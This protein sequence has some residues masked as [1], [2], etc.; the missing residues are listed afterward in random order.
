MAK[1]STAEIH[2]FSIELARNLVGR[3]L[4]LGQAAQ[5]LVHEA[6]VA[7]QEPQ[8]R[9]LAVVEV[10]EVDAGIVDAPAGILALGHDVAA[11]H[12]DL[13]LGIEDADVGGDLGRGLG[14]VVLGI[15]EALVGQQQHG[16]LA[17][18]LDAGEAEI[19]PAVAQELGQRLGQFLARQQHGV[20]EMQPALGIG[21]ELV[22]QDAL[23]D[24]AAVLLGLAQ[25]GLGGHLGAGRR[26][27]RDR[28][29]RVVDQ[30]L[31][32]H[33]LGAAVGQPVV[34]RAG[35]AAQED[36]AGVARG[37]LEGFGCIMGGRIA[38]GLGGQAGEPLLGVAPIERRSGPHRLKSRRWPR[39]APIPPNPCR[40]S[41]LKNVGAGDGI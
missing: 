26:Q 10:R 1:V 31:D 32:A 8:E 36:E 3:H 4:G 16:R 39:P 11:Q 24:L 19:E 14:R 38:L 21:Q 23:V 7:D 15:E 12:R 33:E 13:A 37:L 28:I 5:H 25:L 9:D 34:E 22:A 35:M 27:A 40:R 29:G 20:A 17:V 2:S 41:C 30:L 6:Q 18:A